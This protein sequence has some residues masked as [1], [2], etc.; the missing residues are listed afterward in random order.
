MDAIGAL[1]A[2]RLQQP[3]RPHVRRAARRL[4]GQAPV[5]AV[6]AQSNVHV[7]RT[8]RGVVRTK[9]GKT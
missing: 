6:V 1:R 8:R 4:A 7:A 9:V 3:Q 5:H 2:Q